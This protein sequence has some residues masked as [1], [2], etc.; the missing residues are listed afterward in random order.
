MSPRLTV[1]TIALNE[2]HNLPACLASVA[3]ADEIIVID[4]GST[5]GTVEV[6]RRF[7][8]RVFTIAWEGYGSARNFGLDRA[9]GEWVLWLDADERVTPELAGEIRQTMTGSD[10][11]V[12]AFDV[13][14]RA[15]FLGRWIRHCGWYPSRVPRLF[16]KGRARF[17]DARVHEQLVI[18]GARGSLRYDLLHYTDPDLHHYFAKFNRYTSLAA[19]DMAAAGKTATVGD[20]IVRPPF[21]FFRMFVLRLGMLDGVHGFILCV[22]SSLYVFTKYAK[23]WE[24]GWRRKSGGS[25]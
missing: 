1:I 11:T 5:D 18:D 25:P 6:A 7:T 23:L 21:M 22:V 14:R 8:P 13:A 24:K 10:E 4:S 17:N 19:D 16:R 3:W 20:M 2:E 15:Y 9:S 12:A